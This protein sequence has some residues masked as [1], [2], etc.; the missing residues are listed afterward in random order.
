MIK[1][2]DRKNEEI[3]SLKQTV[4][5]KDNKIEQLRT[6][7]KASVDNIYNEKL[8]IENDKL[9]M[10]LMELF[11]AYSDLY[12]HAKNLMD[13]PNS[14]P[15]ELVDKLDGSL[16]TIEKIR[17]FLCEN[18]IDTK[19]IEMNEKCS[20]AQQTDD[21]QIYS[22]KNSPECMENLRSLIN[23]FRNN[24]LNYKTFLER[25]DQIFAQH[26]QIKND[27]SDD[28]Q[29]KR[30]LYSS[31]LN[32][33]SSSS[34]SSSPGQNEHNI[35]VVIRLVNFCCCLAIFFRFVFFVVSNFNEKKNI[36]PFKLQVM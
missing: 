15:S 21:L 36:I 35:N 8:L 3:R 17:D 9:K 23:D 14:D 24:K 12:N 2:F 22:G 32:Q 31:L 18:N 28:Q 1:E 26:D 30:Q 7:I 25:L 6:S 19:M 13:A 16:K 29:F 20:K 27:T 10:K 34:S 11:N 5:D 33:S 4:F